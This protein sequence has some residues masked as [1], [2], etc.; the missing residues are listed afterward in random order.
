MLPPPGQRLKICNKSPRVQLEVTSNLMKWDRSLVLRIANS[1]GGGDKFQSTVSRSLSVL[2][3][4]AHC[5]D[6][7]QVLWLSAKFTQL[8]WNAI[9]AL[10]GSDALPAA[11]F[12]HVTSA[13]MYVLA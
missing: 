9:A 8:E 4:Q 1:N 10:A 11:A 5:R 6:T 2:V 13:S 7:Q 12:T 3:V